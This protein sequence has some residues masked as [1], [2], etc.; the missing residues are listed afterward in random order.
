MS[1]GS[2][3]RKLIYS[4]FT[5]LEF[6]NATSRDSS[7]KPGLNEGQTIFTSSSSSNGSTS[8]ISSSL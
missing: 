6:D 2:Y 7:F 4:L 3:L 1:G 5:L 8:E